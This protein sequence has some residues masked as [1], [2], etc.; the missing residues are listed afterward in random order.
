MAVSRPRCDLRYVVVQRPTAQQRHPKRRAKLAPHRPRCRDEMV[1]Q[2]FPA[3]PAETEP[4][5][6]R[7]TVASG[8]LRAVE[9]GFQPGGYTGALNK[10]SETSGHRGFFG[11]FF[12]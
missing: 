5:E 6:R 3:R 9:P 12:R 8:I 2:H 10:A 7:E 11:C 1:E 4:I